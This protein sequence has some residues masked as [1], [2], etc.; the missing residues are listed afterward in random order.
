MSEIALIEKIKQ[1][2]KPHCYQYQKRLDTYEE[3]KERLGWDDEFIA[4]INL[5]DFQFA[6]IESKQDKE[7][8][9]AF[10]K[11]YEWLGTVAPYVTHW[12]TATYKGELGGVIMMAMP[13]AFSKLLGEN[14]KS[15]ERLIGRGASASWA[16]KNLGS[17]FLKWCIDWMVKNTQYRLFTCYSD[18]QAGEIGQIYQSL[19]F[20]C[21]GQGAG[22][23]IRCINPYNPDKLITD[24]TFRSRSFYKRYAKDLGIEWHKEWNSDQIVHWELIPDDVEERLRAYSKE[25]YKKAVKIEFPSK[26]KY[27]YVQG[28][29]KTET[30]ELRKLFESLNK[31]VPYPKR[32]KE[33]NN[34]ESKD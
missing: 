16:P 11:R 18:V 15:V 30:R 24:R 3:D 28:R 1:Y 2:N 26:W 19:N 17:K 12:F 7:L 34:N 8:A 4:N 27:A 21:L 25:M 9:T 13:T 31:T 33:T 6:Y 22:T 20:Y 29:T 23:N 32:N 10:I 14:T 5:D